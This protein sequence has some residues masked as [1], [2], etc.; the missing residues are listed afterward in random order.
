MIKTKNYKNFLVTKEI[1]DTVKTVSTTKILAEN[2]EEVSNK[3][4]KMI[5]F[6][7]INYSCITIG[8]NNSSKK[9]L[10][11]SVENITIEEIK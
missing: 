1:I 11:S 8:N 6:Q 5:E 4:D 2:E 9:D 10:I 3:L 7:D